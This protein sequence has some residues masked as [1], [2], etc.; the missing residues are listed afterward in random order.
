[1]ILLLLL[2]P[3]LPCEGVKSGSVGGGPEHR[4]ETTMAAPACVFLVSLV[5]GGVGPVKD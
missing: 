3:L 5:G 1:M 4:P 2:L